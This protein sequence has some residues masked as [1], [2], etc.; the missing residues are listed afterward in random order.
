MAFVLRAAPA[1][2]NNI[3]RHEIAFVLV[4]SVFIAISVAGGEGA[5]APSIK[6]RTMMK[7]YDNIAQRCL[8]AV[9]FFS[10]INHITVINNNINKDEGAL[11]P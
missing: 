5:R 2:F 11:G 4:K 8:V 9:N 3:G 6:I 1:Y 10:V 7:N